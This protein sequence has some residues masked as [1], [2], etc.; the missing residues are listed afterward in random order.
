MRHSVTLSA[1]SRPTVGHHFGSLLQCPQKAWY[2][3]FGD[4]KQKMP[5]PA[6]LLALQ[7]E[8]I[9]HERKI[10]AD[11]Y[12]NAVRIPDRLPSEERLAQTLIALRQGVPALLQG[13]LRVGN[14]VG[15]VDVLELVE[16]GSGP[17][18]SHLYRVGEFKRAIALTSAHVFQAAWYSELLQAHIGC[19][20]PDV[21]FILGDSTRKIV[22]FIDVR[23]AYDQCKDALRALQHP[24]S[25]P[26]PHLCQAC[27]SCPWRGLCVPELIDSKHLSLIP[28]VSR[29]DCERLRAANVTT[30]TDLLTKAD[31]ALLDLGF[32][33]DE[34]RN[35]KHT[36]GR[37]TSGDA[38]C[39]HTIRPASIAGLTAVAL[40]YRMRQQKG[41]LEHHPV[42]LWYES[43][44]GPRAIPVHYSHE[45]I[46]NADL[47][48]LAGRAGVAVY[49]SMDLG[50][51][52]RLVH[53]GKVEQPHCVD[54]LKLVEGVVHAPLLG[55]ELSQVLQVIKTAKQKAAT[56]QDRVSAIRTVID[57][58]VGSAGVAA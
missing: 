31:D 56:G 15:V 34:L 43:A 36:L 50:M 4:P 39:R 6:Y 10:C 23:R 11:L 26:G 21:F 27:S 1:T 49:G 55:L 52:M 53:N 32:D 42:A 37:L 35:V 13:Y 7:N 22:N 16:K 44:S 3:Y 8:G 20:S 38:V 12:T 33:A 47:S 46:A 51:F 48:P 24:N 17:Q 58:I 19:V 18:G 57:W 14:D 2:D 30:W 41:E 29:K 28:G 40:E 9:E 54:V 25:R 45:A 5:A